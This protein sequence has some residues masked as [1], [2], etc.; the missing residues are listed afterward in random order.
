MAIS[1]PRSQRPD[2]NLDHGVWM[3]EAEFDKAMQDVFVRVLAEGEVAEESDI[4]NA[5]QEGCIDGIP[6]ERIECPPIAFDVI[7]LELQTARQ[8][9]D[10][11]ADILQVVERHREG[12]DIAFEALAFTSRRHHVCL[13]EAKSATLLVEM[14]LGV[15]LSILVSAYL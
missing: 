15:R 13:G 1:S 12:G 2:V 4:P 10:V 9:S 14:Y 7:A 5:R 11:P 8:G 6:A 3:V